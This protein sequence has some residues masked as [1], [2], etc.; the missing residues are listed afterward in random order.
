MQIAHLSAPALGETRCGDIAVIREETAATMIAVV[1]VLGHGPE[2]ARIAEIAAGC[3]RA[4]PI[5]RAKDAMALLHEALRGSRGAAATV[6]V[7]RGLRIDGCGVGNVELRVLGTSVPV[8]LTPGIVGQRM[9]TLREFECALAT[10]DRLICFSDGI[11]SRVPFAELRALAPRE[12]C[13]AIMQQHRRNHDDGTVVIADLGP[14][15]RKDV[16]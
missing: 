10:G 2:A 7:L 12:A 5:K 11:S 8:I 3:L 16:S 4:A 9:S 6:F 1:D 13:A 14:L 15:Q